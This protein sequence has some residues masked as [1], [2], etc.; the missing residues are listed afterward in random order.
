MPKEMS[1]LKSLER[2]SKT[3]GSKVVSVGRYDI[4]NAVPF[5]LLFLRCLIGHRLFGGLTMMNPLGIY[6]MSQ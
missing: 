2:K 6:N 4:K 5:T 3:E 1:R